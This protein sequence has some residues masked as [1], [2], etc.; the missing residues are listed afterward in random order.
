METRGPSVIRTLLD[1]VVIGGVLTAINWLTG[2]ADPGWMLLNPT[3]WLLLPLLVGAR[4]G[5]W[6]GTMA[7]GLAAAGVL[8]VQHRLAGGEVSLQTVAQANPFYFT[9]MVLAGF[10]AGV[11][12]RVSDSEITAM[13]T[14]MR[15]AEQ[16]SEMMEAELNVVREGRS[17][18]QKHVLLHNSGLTTLDDD[19]RKLFTAPEKELLNGLL[20]VLNRQSGLVSAA[21]YEHQGGGRLARLAVLHETPELQQKLH[22]DDVPLAAKA[23]METVTTTV[24]A[25]VGGTKEQPFLAAIPWMWKGK[26]GVLMVQNLPLRNFDWQHLAQMELAVKWAL[27]L[28]T[29]RHQRRSSG[30]PS[31]FV[32][33]EDF[34]FLL[35][36]SLE[37]E[38]VHHLPSVI[39]RADFLDPDQA[40]DIAMV[41]KI[42]KAMPP[43][44]VPT[45]LPSNGSIIALLPF[46]GEMEGAA[47]GRELAAQGARLRT[48]SFSVIRPLDGP[49]DV[50]DFWSLVTKD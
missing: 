33:L 9:G 6:A 48:S 23:L 10:L 35:N 37:T 42:L 8:L 31:A 11:F 1:T 50:T 2:R 24:A 25:P 46:G 28:D 45:R 41:R 40:A 32:A 7:G 29:L 5:L 12:R 47:L 39:C 22:T 4:Y 44:A 27:S 34:L 36:E 49:A 17:Q 38:V 19:L 18:L 15:R 21:F 26:D 30:D 14:S 16:A 13:K 43:T 3:P 20:A